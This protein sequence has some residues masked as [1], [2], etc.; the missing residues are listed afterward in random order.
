M[1]KANLRRI[2]LFPSVLTLSP[3]KIFKHLK[4]PAPKSLRFAV[5]GIK[6]KII[7]HE[8]K[9]KNTTHN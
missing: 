7:R 4:N 8:K 3:N 2:K 6:L 5:S 1:F 9:Q